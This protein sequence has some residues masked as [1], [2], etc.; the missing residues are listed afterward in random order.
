MKLGEAMAA[1]GAARAGLVKAREAEASYEQSA[2][3]AR[4]RLVEASRLC[5]EA[6]VALWE[7]VEEEAAKAGA[8]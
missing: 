1:Y 6:R 4:M 7:S 3:Q 8:L 5:E 2:K